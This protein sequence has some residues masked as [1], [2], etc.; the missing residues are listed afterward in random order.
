MIPLDIYFWFPDK[1]NYFYIYKSKKYR[2][3]S[4]QPLRIVTPRWWFMI[5]KNT[6]RFEP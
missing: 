5:T 6:E 1:L 4:Y 2:C 3:Y